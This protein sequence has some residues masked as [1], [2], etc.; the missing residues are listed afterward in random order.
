MSMGLMVAAMKLRV[1]NPLRKLVL[2]KLA[3]NASDIGE[4]WPSYQHVADQCEISKRSVM[5]HIAALCEAGLLRKEIRKGGPKGNSSN[6]YFLTLD[7]GAPPAPGVVQQIHQ[8]SAAGSPPS[9]SPAPGG[10]AAAAPRISNSLEPVMEPVIE[11][12]TPQASAKVVTGQVVPFVPQQ[13]RVE[14]PADMP[15]PKDQACKTFKVWA[16][17]AM[18]YRKR[19]GAWP[20]W[21]AKT[22][23][24]TALLVDR[25]GSDVA[26]HVAAHFLKTSDAAVLRKCHSLNELLA[27]AESYHTQWVTGQR[28]NGTTARQMERTE[29]NLSAAEQA[30]QMVLAK[31]QAGDRNEYL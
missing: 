4:C 28:I 7:G 12:I 8:G 24:Q 29:A 2:I 20:V 16:N 25:L 9:E 26:H 15:G 18:A 14:I 21:N 3:D 5:N 27:N 22:G 11:P 31:R 23:K 13:P 30:A 10:S 17:Y 6:V 19:Y 1:G